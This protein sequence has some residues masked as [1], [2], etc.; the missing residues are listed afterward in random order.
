ME[1]SDYTLKRY[2][3]SKKLRLIIKN[4][5]QVIITAPYLL[6]QKYIDVF[7]KEQENWI[8][9]KVNVFKSMPQPDIKTKKGDYK[10]YKENARSLAQAKLEKINSFYKFKYN[11]IAIRNQKTRWGSCSARKN[12]NFNYKIVFLPEHLADYVITHELCHIREMNHGPKFWNLI[13]Q[14]IPKYKEFHTQLK[15][16]RM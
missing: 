8:K 6:S 2:K 12:L 15:S 14:T 13:A 5:G 3:K 16:F 9:E 11:K 4:T 7:F 10:K 1:K